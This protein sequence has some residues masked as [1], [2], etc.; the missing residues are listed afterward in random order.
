MHSAMQAQHLACSI[1]HTSPM[2]TD[3]VWPLESNAAKTAEK[4]QRSSCN[5]DVQASVRW[6]TVGYT[7]RECLCLT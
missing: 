7:A 3:G 2:P 6:E 1:Q 5:R 4:T